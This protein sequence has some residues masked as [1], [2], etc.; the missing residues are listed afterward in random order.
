MVF[1]CVALIHFTVKAETNKITLNGGYSMYYEDN[2]DGTVDIT[3]IEVTKDITNPDLVIP[4]VIDGKKVEEVT[5]YYYD[6]SVIGYEKIKSL[7]FEEGIVLVDAHF[8]SHFTSAET[9]KIPTTMTSI[10]GVQTMV[11]LKEIEVAQDNKMYCSEDGILF[12]KDK[13]ELITYPAK[14]DGESYTV[15]DTVKIISSTAFDNGAVLKTINIPASVTYIEERAFENSA[16]CEAINVDSANLRYSSVNG[17]LFNKDKTE[18]LAVTNGN[19]ITTLELPDTLLRIKGY[20]IYKHPSLNKIIFPQSFT[21]ISSNAIMGCYSLKNV[22]F[23]GKALSCAGIDYCGVVTV[24][25][26]SSM[27]NWEDCIKNSS[28]SLL[29]KDYAA[30]K[31]VSELNLEADSDNIAVG[32]TTLSIKAVLNPCIECN[33][34]WTSSNNSVATVDDLGKVI[35]LKQ[36]SATITASNPDGKHIASKTITVTGTQAAPSKYSIIEVPEFVD[37]SINRHQVVSE[38]RNGIYYF[39]NDDLYLYLLENN[40]NVKIYSFDT[41]ESDYF[42]NN[43]LYIVCSNECYI[44]NLETHKM[45]KYFTL[46]GYDIRAVGADAQGRIYIADSKETYHNISMYSPDGEYITSVETEDK[47]YCFDDFDAV[48]G[49]FYYE[50]EYNWRYW[51]YDHWGK[52][53]V[54][55][56]VSDNTIKLI[57]EGLEYACQEYF[58]E[59]NFNADIVAK[60]CIVTTS[61]TFGRVQFMESSLDGRFEVIKTIKRDGTENMLDDSRDD[62]SIGVRTVYNQGRDSIIIYENGKVLNEYDKTSWERRGTFTLQH[63]VYN[64]CKIGD[65][66]I[67]IEKEDGKYYIES[68]NWSDAQH[69]E[70]KGNTAMKSGETQYLECIMSSV[71]SEEVVWSSSNSEVAAVSKSGMVSAWHE[72]AAVITCETKD[73]KEK[74]A[75]T[76]Q[77]TSDKTTSILD[78]FSLSSGV[79]LSQNQSLNNY[80]TWSKTVKSYLYEDSNHSLTRVEYVGDKKVVVE[81]Y[82]LGKLESSKTIDAELELFGGFYHGNDYNYMVYGASNM[83]DS[84]DV[85]VIRVVKYDKDFNKLASKSIS[86]VN[87]YIP[88]EAGSLRMD[89]TAGKLYIYTCH[90]MYQSSDGYHHQANM[91]FVLNEETLDIE[92]SYSDVMNIAQAGY[93][94]HSFNQFIKTDGNSVYRVDHGDANPRAVSITKCDVNGKITSVSYNLL[95]SIQGE[96]GANV[97]GVSVGGLELSDSNCIV[98][99][100]SVDQSDADTYDS[101]GTRNIF[102]SVTDKALNDTQTKWITSYTKND[103]IQTCTPQLV[104][105]DA[106]HFLILWEERDT[107]TG[108]ITTKAVTI[109]EEAT[110]TIPVCSISARLSDCQP[111]VTAD[112]MVRWYVTDGSVVTFYELAPYALGQMQSTRYG[113]INGDGAIDIVDGVLLKKH[114]AKMQVVISEKAADVNGD[115]NIEI[116]DAVLLLKYLAGMKVELGR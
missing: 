21:Y 91:T 1:A 60:N 15:P 20:V 47:V 3:K 69:L 88:F 27:D 33:F 100:N 17:I 24:F 43:K 77:V 114:L 67:A 74:A 32:D 18:L 81:N 97:T 31:D 112:E 72:G 105:L 73:G 54:A 87:T 42:A 64:L 59:H 29:W 68:I 86:A 19:K 37:I 84:D 96:H 101:R 22:V 106:A 34:A 85:E 63:Y 4:S 65:T 13:T 103:K 55:A 98:V 50:T 8:M 56:N 57:D 12:N 46:N 53:V 107:E 45:E 70:I 108:Q 93:V 75:F 16:A 48:T 44:F 66:I 35:G 82:R 30:Y 80:T 2:G 58:Y 94:S 51:G 113:D 61:T 116:A 76:I 40:T 102:V 11:Q 110:M 9:L 41:I 39:V 79:T 36:G 14:K 109:D 89:E 26:D 62:T 92:D 83:H 28:A 71:Y 99:G 23:K 111:I 38:D 10:K 95:L 52:L 49:N 7:A 78:S 5:P 104:K 115:G 90:E 6:T 25:Y